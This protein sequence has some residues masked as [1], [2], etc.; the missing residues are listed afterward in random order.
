MDNKLLL[1]ARF[2]D[3]YVALEIQQRQ[4]ALGA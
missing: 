2:N 1:A 3:F 4:V